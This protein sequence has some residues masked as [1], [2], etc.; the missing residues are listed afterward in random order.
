MLCKEDGCERPVIAR[1]LCKRDYERMRQQVIAATGKPPTPIDTRLPVVNYRQAHAR[2]GPASAY[3]CST[4]G[5]ERQAANWAYDG[6]DPNELVGDGPNDGNP[7]SINPEHYMP[8]CLPCHRWI[9]SH[10]THCKN[11]HEF[12]PENTYVYPNGTARAGHRK[13]RTCGREQM[14]RRRAAERKG[15]T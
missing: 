7:Y 10:K 14:R 12:T 15:L 4:V 13:C 1:G 3:P 6:Q 11:G 9:D 5:C 2:L 8:L